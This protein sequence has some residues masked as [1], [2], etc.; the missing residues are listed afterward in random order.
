MIGP[1]L[2]RA[3]ALQYNSAL[4]FAYHSFDQDWEPLVHP[5]G[6]E[7]ISMSNLVW[8]P[9]PPVILSYGV[10]VLSVTAAL[11]IARLLDIHLVTAPVSLF[12][13]AIM[14]SAWFGGVRSGLFAVALSLLAFDYYFVTPIYS[15]AVDIKELPRIIIFALSALFVWSLS[16]AQRSVTESLRDARDDLNRTVQELRRINEALQA[17]NAERKRAAEALDK[18]QAELAH[19]TRVMTMGELVASIAHEVNQPLGAIVTNGQ[20][21]L[22]LLSRE[23]PNVD[24]S[25]EVIERMVGDGMR[26]SEVIKRI[27]ALLKK[28]APEKALLNINETIQEVVVMANSEA[29]RSKVT[30]LTELAAGLP[31]VV[32]DRVQLQQVILNL[33]LNGRDAMSGVEG[34][35]GE[36]LISS[37]KTRPDEV[38]VAVRDCGAGLDPQDAERI[39]DPF[40]TTKSEG[41]GL[42]LSISRTIIEAHGGRL[43]ATPNDG[44]GATIQFILPANS[45]SQS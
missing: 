3:E 10:A 11:I 12:L 31:P 17:E 4:G 39:F 1:S 6:G 14:L 25:R 23:P 45:E 28:T 35:P 37:R 22:R 30:L 38:L 40:F 13:C 16:A 27:R 20:A 29:H 7:G 43:W 36:L 41:M 9:R 32:G 24:K 26:A 34:Q 18:A 5:P 33:I 21:C 44:K 2:E 8:W 19:V 15:L 42:G